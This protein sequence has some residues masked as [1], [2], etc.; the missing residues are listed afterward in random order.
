MHPMT[1]ASPPRPRPAVDFQRMPDGSGVLFD[2]DTGQAYAVNA[3]AAAVWELCDGRPA[4]AIAAALG[5]RYAAPPAVIAAS[6][7]ALLNH[8]RALALLEAP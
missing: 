8:F 5:E 6:V 7:A 1:T 2:G 4:A 3:T